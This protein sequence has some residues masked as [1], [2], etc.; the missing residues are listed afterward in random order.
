MTNK[1]IIFLLEQKNISK[2]LL[3]YFRDN[4]NKFDEFQRLLL[5]ESLEA[6]NENDFYKVLEKNKNKWFEIK[7]KLKETV[8]KT[9][10]LMYKTAEK[11]LKKNEEKKSEWLLNK[12]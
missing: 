6:N 2:D 1:Q 8:K 5:I 4:I 11:I 7:A 12:I 10:S 9:I 3:N